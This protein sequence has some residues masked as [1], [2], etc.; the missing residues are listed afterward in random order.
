MKWERNL[1]K[2]VQKEFKHVRSKRNPNDLYYKY[3]SVKDVEKIP[4]LDIIFLF[5]EGRKVDS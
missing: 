3:Q 1:Y 5:G 2:A 4:L